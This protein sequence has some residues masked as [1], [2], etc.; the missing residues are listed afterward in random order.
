MS[1]LGTTIGSV[2]ATRCVS[3]REIYWLATV[4]TGEPGTFASVHILAE[5]YESE[6]AALEAARELWQHTT[7][8]KP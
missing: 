6:G 1:E 2:S 7:K 5:H 3:G 8:A 4:R